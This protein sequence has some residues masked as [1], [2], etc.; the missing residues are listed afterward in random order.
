MQTSSAKRTGFLSQIS[1]VLGRKKEP[2][3][4]TSDAP[5]AESD[6]QSADATSYKFVAITAYTEVAEAIARWR[7]EGLPLN[8]IK[9]LSVEPRSEKYKEANYY[10]NLHESDDG[11]KINNW[12][13]SELPVL[14][15]SGAKTIVE[16]G[17][18]NGKFIRA[19]SAIADSVT[20]VDFAASPSL[21][22]LPH[23]VRF[24][25]RNVVTDDLPTGELAC[26]A[27][28]LEHFKRE[29]IVDVVAKI[30]TVAPK[31][32]HLIACYD[33]GHSHETIVNPGVWL[34]IFRMFS[35]DYKIADIRPRRNDPNQLV[36]VI[37]NI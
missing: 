12:L 15:S 21:A 29:D 22:D 18:G 35:P 27:D 11:Y 37:S 33:D 23:N 31:Q 28:V 26:S 7:P 17:C 8:D 13:V 34:S 4:P 24:A 1:T 9:E 32:Y 20:G 30:H 6:R 10:Q 3:S 36:C 2:T 19:A 5:V 14:Q 16:I 25:Q